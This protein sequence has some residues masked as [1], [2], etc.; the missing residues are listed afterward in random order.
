MLHGRHR[1]A[2]SSAP[3]KAL[4][5]ART[6][7]ASIHVL[8]VSRHQHVAC[9][10]C[11]LCTILQVLL[12]NADGALPLERGTKVLLTGPHATTTQDLG[13]KFVVNS[14]LSVNLLV[15]QPF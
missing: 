14:L 1:C 10:T 12:K 15:S 4:S 8:L 3:V 6:K 5:F 7:R 11:G 13:G 9:A 2:A